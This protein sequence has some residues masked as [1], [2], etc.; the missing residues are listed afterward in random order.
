MTFYECE[1]TF[2][3]DV[4][5]TG[6]TVAVPTNS[7]AVLTATV[8]VD[9]GNSGFHVSG[10][11]ADAGNNPFSVTFAPPPPPAVSITVDNTEVTE[12]TDPVFTISSARNAPAGGLTVALTVTVEGDYFCF[13]LY[14]PHRRDHQCGGAGGA[15]DG[16]HAER[17]E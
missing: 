14:A 3:L 16:G 9:F 13:R 1:L 10:G 5:D 17:H 8:R 11:V 7:S 6:V 12:G 15:A 2:S 4:G